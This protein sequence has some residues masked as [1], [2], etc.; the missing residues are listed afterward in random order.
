MRRLILLALLS[1]APACLAQ[2]NPS[3]ATADAVLAAERLFWTN[4]TSA[5]TAGLAKQFTPDFRN[6]EQ[7][8]WDGPQVLH[9]V[10]VFFKQCTLAP[11]KIREPKVVFLTP[12]IAT[13]TYR[14]IESP[15]CQGK[16]MSGDTNISTVWVLQ[17]GQWKMHLHTEYAVPPQ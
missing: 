6:V 10:S 1:F 12:T 5:N 17:Q 16:T 2:S 14:A 4:Y 7:E 3:T 11:V 9:F 15:S 8:T 13:L